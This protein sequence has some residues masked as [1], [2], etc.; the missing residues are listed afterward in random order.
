MATVVGE[1][2]S[3]SGPVTAVNLETGVSRVLTL[4]SPVYAGEKIV[5]ADSSSLAL[6]MANG[7]VVTLSRL[8]ELTLTADVIEIIQEGDG[9]STAEAI[10]EIDIL[11]KALEEA[12][13]AG[14][15]AVGS[16]SDGG[17]V[18]D[19][20]AGEG[21]ITF[22]Y[23]P[24]GLGFASADVLT[25]DEA[26]PFE[27]VEPGSAPVVTI[28]QEPSSA[29]LGAVGPNQPVQVG[30]GNGTVDYYSPSQFKAEDP[31][32][33]L[34]EATI[35]VDN[36]PVANL[37][38]LGSVIGKESFDYNPAN[39]SSH[40]KSVL[41]DLV[42]SGPMAGNSDVME[43]Q[44]ENATLRTYQDG[45][46][47]VVLDNGVIVETSSDGEST[48]IYRENGGNI[49]NDEMAEAMT[50]AQ[51]HNKG[52]L[53]DLLGSDVAV[54]KSY[55]LTATDSQGNTS[56]TQ[57]DN[58]AEVQLL[59][60]Y[61]DGL[62]SIL[63]VPLIDALGLSG[64]VEQLDNLTELDELL[65]GQ[66]SLTNSLV[67][68]V[69]NTVDPLDPAVSGLVEG[70][71]PVTD[72][73][74]TILGRLSG[75]P[76]PVSGDDPLVLDNLGD[77]F[78][79]VTNG[80]SSLANVGGTTTPNEFLINIGKS[81]VQGSL[82][83]IN[84]DNPSNT[85]LN[86]DGDNSQTSLVNVLG[87]NP[88]STLINVL[89]DNSQD[90]LINILGD[91]Q[92]DAYI[93]ALSDDQLLSIGR[94]DGVGIGGSAAVSNGLV[95]IGDNDA[96]TSLIN[97]NDDNADAALVNIAGND[98]D[99]AVVNIGGD[100]ADSALVN[101]F[102]DDAVSALVNAFGND[103]PNALI[104]AFGDGAT[105]ALVNIAGDNA[106]GDS[107]LL[108][109]LLG[110]GSEDAIL[111]ILGDN[112]EGSFINLLSD[113]NLISSSNSDLNSLLEPTSALSA[114]NPNDLINFLINYGD[115]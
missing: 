41:G 78:L 17:V 15:E 24:S 35:T 59:Q 3:I 57:Y 102:G 37:I 28:S 85:V 45:S 75:N 82:I 83:N 52:L 40:Q 9:D 22:G 74:K 18:V 100:S 39:L 7:E 108:A 103:A 84:G 90:T 44:Y 36:G 94:T 48:R 32:N 95:N 93:S 29:L 58:L 72:L 5:T 60:G 111:N 110:D 113:G 47:Q 92:S 70:L 62:T 1:V 67:G 11:K 21:E 80:N 51:P 27:V 79:S 26:D 14:E 86:L 81:N 104:N 56:S 54:F 112:S 42:A 88:E 71:E 6:T 106:G 10:A 96:N 50:Y 23:D 38:N 76:V 33:D 2:T 105:S 107:L 77:R 49:S 12:P 101:I 98:A 115:S 91:A 114:L 43:Y 99:N 63:G 69:D 61:G 19:R 4:G 31:D 66:S 64:P 97:I 87:D 53:N 20:I 34:R 73:L 68:T 13:G 109:N 89:G 46:E 8:S 65:L 30:V 25:L 55:S 16:A